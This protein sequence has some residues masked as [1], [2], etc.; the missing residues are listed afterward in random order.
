MTFAVIEAS[1]CG[2]PISQSGLSPPEA[3][4]V[5]LAHIRRAFALS[6]G[7]NGYLRMH[8]HRGSVRRCA[9]GLVQP[10]PSRGRVGP[11]RSAN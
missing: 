9:R 8:P 4:M 11:L 6:N 10:A 3:N 5:Y 2:F 7:T 1:G